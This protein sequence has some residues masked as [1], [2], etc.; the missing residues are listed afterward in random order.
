MPTE[1]PICWQGPSSGLPL[2]L[3]ATQEYT[4]LVTVGDYIDRGSASRQ[5]ADLLLQ[6]PPCFEPVFLRGNHE[7]MLRFLHGGR[8]DQWLRNGGRA[9][10]QSYGVDPGL[11]PDQFR[12]APCR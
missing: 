10:A 11:P 4:T 7:D 2:M 6:L 12:A 8:P 9:T 5:V 1:P 3:P